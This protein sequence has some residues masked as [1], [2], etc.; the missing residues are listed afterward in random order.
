MYKITFLERKFKDLKRFDPGSQEWFEAR[1][2]SFGGSEIHNILTSNPKK[3]QNIIETKLSGPNPQ[4]D[5]TNWGHLFE[6]VAKKYIDTYTDTWLLLYEFGTLSH[7]KY[8]LSYSPDGIMLDEKEQVKLIE[9]KCPI[10]KNLEKEIDES[11]LFQI[12][13]GMHVFPVDGGMF[14][15]FRF[16]RCL[17]WTSCEDEIYDHYYH[18]E[19]KE[20][21]SQTKPIAFG[22]LY[23]DTKNELFDLATLNNM[24]DKIP[25]IKPEIMI[26][27]KFKK[28]NGYVL[29]WKLFEY[30]IQT[31]DYQPNF[32]QE[33]E[34]D[35]WDKYRKMENIHLKIMEE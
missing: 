1:Q 9:I 2:W 3:F 6:R 10:Y 31:I 23:W 4:K 18:K 19:F 12:Q 13:T 32:L 26:N 24:L 11:Y 15:R 25:N 30:K 29:M 35:I 5:I 34:K 27:E 7:S 28:N 20:R 21:K 16:R 33:H 8:P 17:L 22:Y 14:M